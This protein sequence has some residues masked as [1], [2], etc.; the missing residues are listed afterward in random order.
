MSFLHKGL[1]QPLLPFWGAERP[2]TQLP[3]TAFTFILSQHS[4]AHEGHECSAFK[5]KEQRKYFLSEFFH[6]EFSGKRR[7]QACAEYSWNGTSSSDPTVLRHLQRRVE[8]H[9]SLPTHLPNVLFP[10]A[11]GGHKYPK[12]TLVFE[13]I[14]KEFHFCQTSGSFFHFS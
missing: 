14:S 6:C 4:L 13:K 1:P 2:L 9:E 7:K 11:R 12:Y 3:K 5:Q 10:W 8:A